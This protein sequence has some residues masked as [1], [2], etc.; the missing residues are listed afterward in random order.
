MPLPLPIISA[1]DPRAAASG[2]IDPLGAL[3][4]YTA[5]AS[6]LF[7]G[8]TTI[9]LRPR[10]LSW[11]C[12]GLRLLDELPD[13]PRGGQAG[14]AR[15]QRI[16]PWERLLAL[17]TGWHA[18]ASRVGIEDPSWR[19]LRGVSYVRAAVANNKTSF[20]FGLLRNQAGVGGVGTYWV[21]LVHGGLVEDATAR[22]T[23]RGEALADAFLGSTGT[24]S[25]SR[26]RGA[27]A[28]VRSS[29]SVEEL[30]G[31]GAA[32]S[33]DTAVAGAKERR[34]LLDAL[35]EPQ[36]HR[37]MAAAIGGDAR[38]RSTDSCFKQVEGRLAKLRDRDKLA[39]TLLCL[40]AVARPFEALHAAMLD[41][42]DRLR[43][44]AIDGRPV[45]ADAAAMLAGAPGN[46]PSLEAGLRA[47]IEA[48]P[49][50]PPSVA[51]PAR[52]FL[53][54]A[55]QV[56][57]AKDAPSLLRALLQLHERVQAGKTDPS[58]RPKQPWIELRPRDI[59]VAPRFA[60]EAPPVPRV[61][62]DFTHSYRVEAFAGMLA[63]VNG[64]QKP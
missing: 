47:V 17:S 37:L 45:P 21:T 3:R 12:A 62:G 55:E 48:N 23:P 64:W 19:V 46:L 58:R 53:S 2:S 57:R 28:G 11:V 9:T 14:R 33:L 40:L 15:R 30:T 61:V 24:P 22:L 39:A 7:P 38:A 63:E 27:L 49:G 43:S 60:L 16:L 34:L 8:A 26:L 5:I 6:T 31:L 51:T 29:L 20:D 41:R 44:A 56:C 25:R 4:A 52:Q 32:C 13:A 10:Y 54:A 36:A 35:L 42:F 50:L 1:W 59:V 18:K